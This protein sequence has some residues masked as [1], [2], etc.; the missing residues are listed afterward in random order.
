VDSQYDIPDRRHRR[1]Q[2]GRPGKTIA[3]AGN[4]PAL[5]RQ[6]H[7]PSEEIL[8]MLLYSRYI[9]RTFFRFFGLSLAAF[10]GL[11]L[12]VEFFERIDDFI[13]YHASIGLSISYFVNKTPLI[14]TQVA[15]LACLMSVFMT[16]GSFTRTGELTAMHAGG[17]SLG[18]IAGPLL[19]TGLYLSLIILAANE[20]VVPSSVKRA[21]HIL[22]TEVRG[23]PAVTYKRDKIW[24]RHN[25]QILNIRLAS[26]KQQ[27][28]EGITLLTFNDQFRV[29]QRLDA[30]K[31]SFTDNRWLCRQV[32]FRTFD[33]ASGNLTS[34][35]NLAQKMVNLPVSPDDFKVPG[36]KRN[37]DLS[38]SELRH[39]ARKLRKEG[40]NSTRFQ[41]DMHAR[42][43]A[44][45]AC[46]VMA[47]LGIPFA[48]RKGRGTSLALGIA[49]SV[50]IGA[51]YFIL[52]AALLAFGYSGA[53]PPV[54]AA[55]GANVLFLLFGCW[56][57]LYG[58][59]T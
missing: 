9:L 10:V 35:R 20:F 46:L 26:P 27:T 40:Y 50:G 21:R 38:I 51:I 58:E 15:P 17:I 47:F 25:E 52:H 16:L 48:I 33:P 56:L 49:V 42:I 13:E 44:P 19:R 57:F 39:L 45:F 23:G 36:S 24:L 55:W 59:E 8:T 3:I 7:S 1:T 18:R 11:Y 34:E 32:V 31:A 41:V 22:A 6:R 29:T 12:L 28:L 5:D 43:A 53:F 4:L 54:I 37:E 30:A 14:I 2:I